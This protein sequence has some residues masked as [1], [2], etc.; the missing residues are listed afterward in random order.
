MEVNDDYK[1]KKPWNLARTFSAEA[2]KQKV[3]SKQ[4]H[5]GSC[6]TVGWFFECR[7]PGGGFGVIAGFPSFPGIGQSNCEHPDAGAQEAPQFAL[8]VNLR[9]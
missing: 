8:G 9:T 6:G 2:V 7:L 3:S 4:A 5:L 1:S